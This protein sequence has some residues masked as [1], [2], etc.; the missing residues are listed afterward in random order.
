MGVVFPDDSASSTVFPESNKPFFA[1]GDP[2]GKGNGFFK[3]GTDLLTS[4]SIFS[5]PSE[6]S[7]PSALSN[8]SVLSLP[9]EMSEPSELSK[10]A[11][12]SF[13]DVRFDAE[14]ALSGLSREPLGFIDKGTFYPNEQGLRNA[15]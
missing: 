10:I 2:Y 15:F 3:C 8:P 12:S 1:V 9:G 13:H 7:K 5:T 6:L 11:R 4:P 14:T